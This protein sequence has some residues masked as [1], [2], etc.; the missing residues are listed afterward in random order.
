MP[1][2][3][4]IAGLGARSVQT[5]RSCDATEAM[6]AIRGDEDRTRKKERIVAASIRSPVCTTTSC[7]ALLHALGRSR[8]DTGSPSHVATR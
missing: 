6:P 5:L 8:N 3:R 4:A 2:L 7:I 1:T